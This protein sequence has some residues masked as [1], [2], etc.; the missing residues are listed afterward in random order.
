MPIAVCT[1]RGTK[2]IVCWA[3]IYSANLIHTSLP[4]LQVPIAVRTPRGTE[5]IVCWVDSKATFGDHRTHVKQV[6]EQYC[7]YVNRRVYR[8]RSAGVLVAFSQYP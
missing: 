5:H 1:P 2:E 7:T 3:S 4:P 6:E 8:S